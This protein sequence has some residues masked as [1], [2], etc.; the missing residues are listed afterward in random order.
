MLL[1]VDVA[2]IFVVELKCT[3][4]L[5]MMGDNGGK[6]KWRCWDMIW[7]DENAGEQRGMMGML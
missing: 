5:G 7:N 6:K 1:L 3:E 4:T 2:N